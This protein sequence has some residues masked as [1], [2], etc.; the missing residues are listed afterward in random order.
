MTRGILYD[1][2]PTICLVSSVGVLT[3]LAWQVSE[4]FSTSHRVHEIRESV[5]AALVAEDAAF[6]AADRFRPTAGKPA[7]MLRSFSVESPAGLK[8]RVDPVFENGRRS[9]RI[10]VAGKKGRSYTFAC[11]LLPGAAPAGLGNP[12]SVRHSIV[13]SRPAIRKWLRHNLSI[14]LDPMDDRTLDNLLDPDVDRGEGGTTSPDG[15]EEDGSIALLR[16]SAGTDRPDYRT[17]ASDTHVWRPNIPET[18]V[19]VLQGNLWIDRGDRPLHVDLPRSLTV[20]VSGN[21]YI[22]RSIVVRGEGRLI[23]VARRGSEST[24]V[25]VDGDGGFSAGDRRV[26]A[27]LAT[28]D[29]Y[30]GSA[31]GAGAIYLGLP[32]AVPPDESPLEIHASLVS[33]AESYVRAASTTVRGAMVVGLGITWAEGAE[34]HLPGDSLPN[35][36]RERVPGF[37][38]SGVARPGMLTPI[39]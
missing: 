15:F 34:L 39:H 7:G 11:D 24:F 6:E 12:L 13:V 22:G 4:A 17:V 19:K 14:R 23:L 9:L 27:A 33:E 1:C 10:A 26:G 32:G 38:R 20:I 16:M 5:V 8:S 3:V 28:A 25:D 30:R 18:G 37:R 36:E 21:I 35:I 31:E 2:M 29:A